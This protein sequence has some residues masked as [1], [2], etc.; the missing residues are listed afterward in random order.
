VR[1]LVA[2]SIDV[3]ENEQAPTGAYPACPTFP[4]Y[5]YAWFRDGAFTADGIGQHGRA[6]SAQGFHEWAARV[7]VERRDRV[8]SVVAAARS[9]REITRE[10]FLPTRYTLDGRE[11]DE[12]W[13]DFQLDGYG[14]WLWA[15]RRHLGRTGTDL[16]PFAEAI[17]LT[18]RYLAA[19]WRTPCYDWWEEHC[20]QVHVSTLVSIHAGLRAA[21][22]TGALDEADTTAAATAA[23]E[24]SALV[25]SDGAVDGRL[26]KWLGSTEVDASLL[27]AA[28]PFGNVSAALAGGTVAAVEAQLVD[29]RGVHRYRADVFYGGG[30]WPVL[31]GL[32]GQAYLRAGRPAAAFDQLAWMAATADGAGRLPEQVSDRLLAPESYAEWVERWGPV[33]RP[34][35]WSHGGYLALAAELG[36]TA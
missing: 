30:R 6:T 33:A 14:T 11:S 26:R 2:A 19:T 31:A 3:I 23:G 20:E 18:V 13:W 9:G 32:L 29:Q 24:I 10:Q 25:A 27:S 15:L 17:G 7:V 28:G 12:D 21:L 5:R 4:V 16:R 36:V 34:L 22:A 1:E 8:E 35:L